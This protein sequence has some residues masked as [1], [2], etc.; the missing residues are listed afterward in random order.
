M[1]CIEATTIRIRDLQHRQL[2]A[3]L[4]QA[5][6]SK[7]PGGVGLPGSARMVLAAKLGLGRT[8]TAW[9]TR[10]EVSKEAVGAARFV[11][12]KVAVSSNQSAWESRTATYKWVPRLLFV[13]THRGR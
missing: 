12:S 5:D 2:T 6:G 7:L 3:I 11:P 4:P 10:N 13:R 9:A 1:H 8:L